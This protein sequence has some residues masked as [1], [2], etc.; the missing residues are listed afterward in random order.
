[1]PRIGDNEK[2][3]FDNGMGKQAIIANMSVAIPQHKKS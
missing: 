1:M 3:L 2:L